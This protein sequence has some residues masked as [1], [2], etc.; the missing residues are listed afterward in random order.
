MMLSARDLTIG[1]PRRTLAAHI[2]FSL[3]AGEAVAILGP[4]GSGK[5]TLFRTLL[6]LLPALAGEVLLN[7]TP[8]GSLKPGAIARH[9]AYVPQAASGFFNFSVI[10]V[11]EMARAAHLAWYAQPGIKDHAIA[12]HALA[13]LNIAHFA[14]REFAE[15][16]GGERQLVMIA[17]ALASEAR[18]LLLDEPTASLDYG[19]QFLILDEIARLKTRGVAILFTTHDPNQ[20]LRIAERTLTI[21]RAGAIDIGATRT[22]LTRDSLA[23]LYDINVQ[24][25]PDM[26]GQPITIAAG[27][28]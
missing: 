9:I 10:E 1:Y 18:I 4:N 20:A 6:G 17:R 8:M 25:V 22:V 26:G 19:N 5:T 14:N 12:Q 13:E 15:L 24:L 23:T 2:S 27:A 16:S 3:N 28:P 7:D 11:V 21:S